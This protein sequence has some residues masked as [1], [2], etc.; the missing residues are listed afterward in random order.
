[1]CIY[2]RLRGCQLVRHGMLHEVIPREII[3]QW[4]QRRQTAYLERGPLLVCF[5]TSLLH[6]HIVGNTTIVNKGKWRFEHHA[7]A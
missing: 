7:A 1:M 2:F 6:E 4:R 3:E 5:L